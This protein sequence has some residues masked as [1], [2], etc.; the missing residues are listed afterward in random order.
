MSTEEI[1]TPALLLDLAALDRNIEAM[2]AW[3]RESGV[4][5]R[6]HAKVHKSPAIARRQLAAGAIGLT[7]ATVYEAEAMLETGTHEILIANEVVGTDKLAR[8]VEVARR[9]SVIVAV[10]DAA[11]AR[12]LSST[13]TA[14]GVTIG[15]L[16]DVDVGMHRCGVRSIPEATALADVIATLAGL[17]LVGVMGYE[18][19]VVLEPDRQVRAQRSLDAMDYLARAVDGIRD[20]G[21]AV[22]IVSA[23]GTNT[24]DMTG[25]HEAVTELQAGTYAVMD[26][27]YAD[28]VSRFTPTLS[29]AARVVS[30][31]GQRAV[32]DCGTKVI[33]TD[34][35]AL[36]VAGSVGVVSEVHEEH[37]LIDLE[38]SCHITVGDRVD[39][40]VGYTG[41]TVNLH[42]GYYVVDGDE[43]VDVWPI[44]ARGPGRA[45]RAVSAEAG[46]Q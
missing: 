26:T 36:S 22:R 14:A 35:K 10:D 45:P 24:H 20:A 8:L 16:V 41:G 2:A 1:P 32:L 34:L 43:V 25:V 3:C 21:H 37:M 5:I 42:D 13:A 9:T 19:H 40:P 11:N 17:E 28:F 44:C 15:V 6:P 46:Y 38:P 30:R 4:A 29:V 23:G 39:V 18:G 7:T 33:S 27:G 12:E 31:Q